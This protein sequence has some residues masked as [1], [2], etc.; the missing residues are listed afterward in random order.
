[1][2][3]P[4]SGCDTSSARLISLAKCGLE[5]EDSNLR[6]GESKSARILNDF[7]GFSD[8]TADSAPRYINRLETR[9]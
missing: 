2:S 5:R 7:N 8:E 1:M 9:S 4:D 6:M 3:R